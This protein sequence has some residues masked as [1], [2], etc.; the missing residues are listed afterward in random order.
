MEL[1]SYNYYYECVMGALNGSGSENHESIKKH[2]RKSKFAR[3]LSKVNIISTM[4][5]EKRKVERFN[6]G[7][8]WPTR[9]EWFLLIFMNATKKIKSMYRYN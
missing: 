5:Q 8:Q 6:K 1:I 4:G 9:V 7:Y 3:L 2:S